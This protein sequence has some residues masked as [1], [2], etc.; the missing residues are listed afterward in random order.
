MVFTPDDERKMQEIEAFH[1]HYRR[2]RRATMDI[3]DTLKA[4]GYIGYLKDML[5]RF[6]TL[7]EKMARG[8]V[9]DFVYPPGDLVYAV[10]I[11]L[12]DAGFKRSIKAYKVVGY[13]FEQGTRNFLVVEDGVP[14]APVEKRPLWDFRPTYN[15]AL[16][17]LQEIE[18]E[19][20][21]NEIPKL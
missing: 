18:R 2:F 21:F 7:M 4:V 19:E 17:Y 8:S 1:K 9:I 3:A 14:D 10:T 12:E 13:T 5:S 15:A 6:T 11:S 16:E 20:D